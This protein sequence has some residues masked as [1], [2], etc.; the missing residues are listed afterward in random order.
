MN[1]LMSR[2]WI[3]QGPSKLPQ[4]LIDLIIDELQA[5]IH[6]LRASALAGRVFLHRAR[7]HLFRQ[8]V[9]APPLSA[10]SLKKCRPL[11]S[12]PPPSILRYVR[13][14]RLIG[15]GS[16]GK[17]QWDPTE[18]HGI[19]DA[20]VNLRE[21]SIV[22]VD[23]LVLKLVQTALSSKPLDTL[24]LNVLRFEDRD[25]FYNLIRSFSR[26][27][28]FS[29]HQFQCDSSSSSPSSLI[30]PNELDTLELA[31]HSYGSDVAEMLVDSRSLRGLKTLVVR[32]ASTDDLES[33]GSI[34]DAT[35]DSLERLDV[36]AMRMI[37]GLPSLNLRHL[38]SLLLSISDSPVHQ[39]LFRWWTDTLSVSD[40][41]YQLEELVINVGVHFYDADVEESDVS[42]HFFAES[43]QWAE[44]DKALTR[45]QMRELRKVLVRIQ[46]REGGEGAISMMRTLEDV[47]RKSLSRLSRQSLLEVEVTGV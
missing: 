29:L 46:L 43:S 18:F 10:S 39:P 37:N 7:T 22:N 20:L 5:D 32:P 27:K 42:S 17:E 9:L 30:I 14:L 21:L 3:G 6:T 13:K 19:L 34:L 41:S 16:R 28:H 33:I 45:S 35:K 24:F 8:L 40:G 12:S 47:I 2:F 38:Q 1:R 25:G 31:Y 44:L 15:L 4:E 36:G 23:A 26:L 11:F